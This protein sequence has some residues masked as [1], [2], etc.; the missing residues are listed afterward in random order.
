MTDDPPRIKIYTAEGEILAWA[1][2]WQLTPVKEAR[3]LLAMKRL[4][5]AYEVGISFAARQSYAQ[6]FRDAYVDAYGAK[7]NVHLVHGGLEMFRTGEAHLRDVAFALAST[8]A[9]LELENLAHYIKRGAEML[10]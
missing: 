10:R 3:R 6:V 4:Y 9:P 2:V 7:H 1:V 5:L 8:E